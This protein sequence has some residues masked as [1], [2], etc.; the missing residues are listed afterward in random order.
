MSNPFI[1]TISDI[2]TLIIYFLLIMVII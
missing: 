2:V 1:T